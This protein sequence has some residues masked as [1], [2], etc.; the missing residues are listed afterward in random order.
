MRS[1]I[2]AALVTQPRQRARERVAFE[3]IVKASYRPN[4]GRV[5]PGEL[6][7]IAPRASDYEQ[8]QTIGDVLDDKRWDIW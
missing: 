8:A 5:R 4:I 2:W 6:P 1:K 3:G 7:V